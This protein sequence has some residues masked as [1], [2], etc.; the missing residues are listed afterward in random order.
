IPYPPRA[1]GAAVARFL[2]TEE[3]TGSNPVSPT[4]L[5]SARVSL[6][7]DACELFFYVLAA[8][9]HAMWIVHA[10]VA[11]LWFQESRCRKTA[12]RLYPPVDARMQHPSPPS[13]HVV[14]AKWK[15]ARPAASSGRPTGPVFRSSR[16][17]YATND[18][19]SAT[20]SPSPA[21]PGPSYSN[22]S[23]GSLR[24]SRAPPPVT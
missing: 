19:G 16:C 4:T 18:P 3:V 13:P 23:T 15:L 5:Q 24:S 17:W 10:S 20:T 11:R 21:V 22:G 6:A 1:I 14:C 8:G 2:D 12:L 9:H 7:E